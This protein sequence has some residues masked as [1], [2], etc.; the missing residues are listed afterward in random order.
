MTAEKTLTLPRLGETMERGTIIA[1][2]KAVGD[3]FERGELLFEVETD[4]TA[5]DVPALESGI[6]L[7]TASLPITNPFSFA[8]ISAP[9][10]QKGRHRKTA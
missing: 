3:S 8:P 7:H 9:H 6:L 10:I 1:W 2:R 5:V 4:K